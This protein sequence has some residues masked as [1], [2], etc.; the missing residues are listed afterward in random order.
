MTISVYWKGKFA[1]DRQISIE[2]GGKTI[3]KFSETKIKTY[4][5]HSPFLFNGHRIRAIAVGGATS[6]L[7]QILMDVAIT[8]S[9]YHERVNHD[10]LNYFALRKEGG[11]KYDII[12]WILSDELYRVNWTLLSCRSYN[13]EQADSTLLISE[14]DDVQLPFS[15]IKWCNSAEE[16]AWLYNA[17]SRC[18]GYGVD[19]LDIHTGEVTYHPYPSEDTRQ[20]I[21][22]TLLDNLDRFFCPPIP[23]GCEELLVYEV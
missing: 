12:T 16:I 2:K 14:P 18:C 4:D 23:E 20:R 15:T 5:E 13:K 10:L 17:F 6:E 11:G 8:D 1:T 21:R 3:G 19:V 7:D 22:R 9:T